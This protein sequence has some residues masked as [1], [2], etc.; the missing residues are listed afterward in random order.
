M[1]PALLVAEPEPE[2]A[3]S[4]R[5]LVLETAKF[6]VLTAHADDEAMEIARN[7]KAI[8]AAVVAAQTSSVCESCVKRLKDEFPRL[9]VIGVTPNK[10]CPGAD[11][12]LSS[13]DP[14]GLT[15]LVRKLFG[16]PRK[17]E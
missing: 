16:D 4:T 10:I 3:L 8:S 1:R 6:N 17:H 13:Y 12:V 2:N 7:F 14:E 9:T 5:K 15:V 11:H